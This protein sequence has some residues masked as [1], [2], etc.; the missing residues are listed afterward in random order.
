[1]RQSATFEMH[2]R[3]HQIHADSQWRCWVV[4]KV[5]GWTN[6]KFKMSFFQ[7]SSWK[8]TFRR[9]TTQQCAGKAPWKTSQ[10]VKWSFRELLANCLCIL[11]DVPASALVKLLWAKAITVI[12]PF[13]PEFLKLLSRYGSAPSVKQT[14]IY[15]TLT[16]RSLHSTCLD[17]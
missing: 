3:D 6:W 8:I 7:N 12:A 4:L 14:Y 1:M 16:W 15:N 10:Q 17:K 11:S 2:M 13:P 5:I 9:K